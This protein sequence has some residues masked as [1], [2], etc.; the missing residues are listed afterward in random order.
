MVLRFVLI[1]WLVLLGAGSVGAADEVPASGS[2][3][4]E[5]SAAGFP[6]LSELG[7]RSVALADFVA[8]SEDLLAQLTDIEKLQ[9]VLNAAKEQFLKI[10]NEIKPLG[11]SESWYVDRLY[12]YINQ[13]GQVRQ[14]LIDS[15][16]ELATRQEDVEKIREQAASD[17]QFWE[18]WG[19]ELIK[20]G[21]T[22]PRET[23]SQIQ[24][25]LDR[26]DVAVKKTSTQLLKQQEAVGTF[27]LEVLALADELGQSLAKLRKATFRKNAYS[28]G[29][30]RFY[31]QFNADLKTQTAGGLISAVRVDT[32][33][34]SRNA[35]LF[36]LMAVSFVFLAG[37][38]RH[39]RTRLEDAEEWQFILNH[40]FS[41]ATFFTVAVFWF[42]FP[43][44]PAII[45][46]AFLFLATISATSLA[47]PLLENRRQAKVLVFAAFVVLLTNAFRLI[48][49]PQPLF[50]IY[51]AVLAIIFIPLLVQQVRLSQKCRAPGEG[52]FFRALLRLAM[53]VLAISLVA[54]VAG[55]MNFSTWLIQ[56]TFETGM[57]L[58]FARM[59]VLIF[60]GGIDLL[61]GL[62]AR[63]ESR[64]FK[65]FG[66]ELA[67]RLRKLLKI[68]IYGFSIFYLI[69]VW[70][71]FATMQD[72][73]SY[74]AN[75]SV[76]IGTF[77]LTLQ[78]LVSAVVAFYLS[79]QMSW[80][81]QGMS[82]AQVLARRS[83]DQGVI[84][85]VK[86][87]I[88]YAVVLIGFLIALSFL[89]LGIQNFVVLLGAFGV[90]IGFGL[91]DIVNNFLS[92]LILLFERPIKVGDGVMIDGE[93]GTVKRI[94]LR[95]TVV[96]NLDLAEL[97][98]PNAQMISQKVTNWTLSTRRVRL[99]AHV[100]VAYGS[101]L[102][103]VMDILVEVAEQHPLVLKNPKPLPLFNNFGGS[104]LDFE[105]RVWIANIDQ[106]PHVMND[107]LL[108]IDRRFREENIEIPFSQ[109]DLHLRSVEPGI[110]P[111]PNGEDSL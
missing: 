14:K 49:L 1:L 79:L 12:N 17:R 75:F 62:L 60:A 52:R 47:M 58:L 94:G 21:V 105:L 88:H 2:I 70:R 27:Q 25:L 23:I 71:L 45:R 110:L 92:G 31:R 74:L 101:D 40:S 66:A 72:T 43:V 13:I 57:V 65:Q 54:Q 103:K 81:I 48:S 10:K 83:A 90:G 84:D 82:E 34:L 50:R 53:V 41:A 6:G 19:A 46:F 76:D 80:I 111:F 78:M 30:P 42:W 3:A 51:I 93:Y 38:L 95:S 89:G 37:L 61:I 106:K 29:S 24:K 109:H 44:P 86:K 98:V 39:Y 33:Y 104:S 26:L 97:I 8:H 9:E 77:T 100:G 7:P 35:W 73:W 59:A 18:S 55:F 5:A 28:F 67:K 91:Q 32:E 102:K 64:F 107:L 63:V 68:T 85:A 16:K 99:V 20:Q 87:L 69:P 56:A 11:A 22:I 4:V 36:G 108:A 15:E 96:E